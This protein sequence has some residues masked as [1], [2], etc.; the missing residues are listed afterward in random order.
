MD[1]NKTIV[2]T[3]VKNPNTNLSQNFQSNTAL[4]ENTNTNERDNSTPKENNDAFPHRFK[5]E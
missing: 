4:N 5:G 3:Q 1:N 2:N